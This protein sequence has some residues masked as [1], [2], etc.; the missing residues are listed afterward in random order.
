MFF[1]LMLG[2]HEAGLFPVVFGSDR[3]LLPEAVYLF[4]HFQSA[5]FLLRFNVIKNRTEQLTSQSSFKIR[6]LLFSKFTSYD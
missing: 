6:A 3:I 1:H 2:S 5:L 4:L